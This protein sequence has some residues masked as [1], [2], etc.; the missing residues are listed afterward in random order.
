VAIEAG[1]EE[2]RRRTSRRSVTVPAADGAP[3]STAMAAADPDHRDDRMPADAG[4]G[5]AVMD[6]PSRVIASPLGRHLARIHDRHR[7]AADGSVATYIPELGRADPTWF[8]IAAVTL[9][10]RVRAVGDA[11][12]PFTIQS[13]SKPLTYG[14]VLDDLGEDAVRARIGVEPTGEPFNAITLAPGTGMPLNPMVNAGAITAAGLVAARDGARPLDHLLAGFGRFAGRPLTIDPD[15]FASERTT[16]HRNRAIGQLLRA[17]GAIDGDPD[18]VVETYFAQCSVA[19]TTVDLAVI[20]ATLANGGVNPVSGVRAISPAATQA[21]LAVMASC[22]MYDGAGE[23]L[24]TVG[25]PAKSGVSGGL[26]VVVPGQLGFATFSPPLDVN[27]NSIRGVRACRDLVR[28]LGLHPLRGDGARPGP[29]RAIHRL[30]EISS[31]RRRTPAE[32]AAL[33]DVGRRGLVVELQGPLSF[34]APDEVARAVDDARPASDGIDLL[35]LD[36]GH[37]E[38]IDPAAVDLL[39]S[40]LAEASSNGLEV[41]VAGRHRVATCVAAI[42]RAMARDGGGLLLTADD[43]DAALEVAE[44]RLLAASALPSVAS[45][46]LAE[47]SLVRGLDVDGLA[48]FDARADVRAFPQ[49]SRIVTRGDTADGLYLIE[50]GRISVTVDLP[51]GGRRRLSTLGPGMTFGEAALVDGERRTADVHADTDVVC[52]MLSTE[53]FEALVVAHPGVAATVLRNLLGTVGATAARLTR[54][55]AVLA[56]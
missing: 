45:V 51:G 5:I 22:G 3:T 1:R 21:V 33:A 36:L 55:V 30:G 10:G 11:T 41:I 34:L 26:L 14:L 23:W 16:G 27:G 44:D 47:Q 39:G 17:S 20:A 53:A 8:G 24:Y 4:P 13:I 40:L 50:R 31:K 7:R 25:L 18:L 43:L 42:E 49:G 37:V 38:R 35:V 54:E 9:D 2:T 12:V 29:I 32:R 28:D 46:E 15:V 6:W 48:A 52:R 19:V 56:G